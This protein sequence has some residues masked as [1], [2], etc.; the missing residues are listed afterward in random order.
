MFLANSQFITWSATF[1]A[2]P[3]GCVG[4]NLLFL[5]SHLGNFLQED[6]FQ[7]ERHQHN[8]VCGLRHRRK[9]D[10]GSGCLGVWWVSNRSSPCYR[11]SSWWTLCWSHACIHWRSSSSCSLAVFW[12]FPSPLE[13]LL[14]YDN[15]DPE[16]KKVPCQ[17]E[18]ILKILKTIC[19]P[20]SQTL[21][22]QLTFKIINSTC[23]VITP[24]LSWC[25][26]V[27]KQ[28]ILQR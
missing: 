17:I 26:E 11:C 3:L 7:G 19:Q 9:P 23:I 15:P 8:V 27:L 25:Q 20:L 14:S 24:W 1:F 16:K 12:W 6:L 18:V 22:F 5:L 13:T 2:P 4:R 21:A 28:S 10:E